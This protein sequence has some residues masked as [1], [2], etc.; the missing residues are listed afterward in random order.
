MICKFYK[1]GHCN[2]EEGKCRFLHPKICRKFKQF[3]GVEDNNKGCPSNCGFFHPNA[4]R[5]SL[6]N[7]TCTY[8][9][10]KFY[11]LIDTK[12]IQRKYEKTQNNAPK[13][14]Y[15]KNQSDHSKKE[16]KPKNIN[17]QKFVSKNRF[18]ALEEEVEEE[19]TVA[20]QVFQK[21]QTKI[22]DTLAAIMRRLDAMEEKQD[23]VSTKLT[24]SLQITQISGQHKAMELSTQ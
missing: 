5:S 8:K 20:K 18:A 19:I 14:V 1:N 23:E 16:L 24:Q 11:H 7:K 10:C 17:T 3:G 12:I 9:E 2:K 4:C 6:K 22:T 13:K 21:G 15:S